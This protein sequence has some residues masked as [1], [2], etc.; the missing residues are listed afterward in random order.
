MISVKQRSNKLKSPTS[1]KSL[2]RRNYR[3]SLPDDLLRGRL[4]RGIHFTGRAHWLPMG[5]ITAGLVP[6]RSVDNASHLVSRLHACVAL[7]VVAC[8]C[9]LR[10]VEVDHLVESPQARSTQPATLGSLPGVLAR[11]GRRSL[12]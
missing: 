8:I 5:S 7:H 2:M 1:L 6:T 11:N 9:D 3:R 12:S 10:W 4:N